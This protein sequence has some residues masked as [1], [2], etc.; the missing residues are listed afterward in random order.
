MIRLLR[1]NNPVIG[2][3]AAAISHQQRALEDEPPD[4]ASYASA[5]AYSAAIRAQSQSLSEFEGN[6]HAVHAISCLLLIVLESLRGSFANLEL[7]LKPC[8]Y[9]L[10]DQRSQGQETAEIL[11]QVALLIES[12]IL[13]SVGF[14][15]IA[16]H[17]SRARQLLQTIWAC[18]PHADE[19]VRIE[20]SLVEEMVTTL[21]AWTTAAQ[22]GHALPVCDLDV[23]AV[24][25]RATEVQEMAL[26]EAAENYIEAAQGD[27]RSKAYCG[28]AVARSLLAISLI[29]TL[30]GVPIPQAATLATYQRMVD[31]CEDSLAQLR[32]HESGCA[33][34]APNA[35]SIG[36][37]A[38]A[39]LY[40]V[41]TR[42]K[43]F[44]VRRRALLVLETCPRREGIWTVEMARFRVVAVIKAE[45][46]R[47]S[48]RYPEG[49][50]NN[51]LPEDCQVRHDEI[52]E[53]DGKPV[54]RLFWRDS[55]SRSF[56]I[57]DIPV[58]SCQSIC[59]FTLSSSSIGAFPDPAAPVL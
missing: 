5:A 54:L 9:I 42:C 31:V 24:K 48:Q 49:L 4:D 8:V 55:N 12:Y 43:D 39:V 1:Q 46:E 41:G 15:P 11:D 47:A 29:R 10:Q 3:V 28:F 22:S 23:A 16:M 50:P 27:A 52:L 51:Y 37:G 32:I 6:D 38:I 25:L 7:H 30:T 36:L 2:K 21:D 13:S 45:E 26:N 14:S 44:C 17:A 57:E 59:P 40:S 34:D 19:V 18:R 53:I 58:V 20:R 35:F 33:A 56:T